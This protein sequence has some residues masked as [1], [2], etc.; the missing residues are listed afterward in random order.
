[1]FVSF[2][3]PTADLVSRGQTAFSPPR[4]LSISAVAE[5]KRSGHAR[6]QLTEDPYNYLYLILFMIIMMVFNNSY[7][8]SLLSQHFITILLKLTLNHKYRSLMCILHDI[9]YLTAIVIATRR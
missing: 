7:L 8:A 3:M 4:R 1:M 5:K 2:A 9:S 6:L